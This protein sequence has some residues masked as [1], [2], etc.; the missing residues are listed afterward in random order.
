MSRRASGEITAANRS[1]A[2]G[3]P[4]SRTTASASTLSSPYWST[5]LTGVSGVIR[6][7]WRYGLRDPYTAALDA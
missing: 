4:L 6:S 2:Y 5:G 7:G 1:M 3:R